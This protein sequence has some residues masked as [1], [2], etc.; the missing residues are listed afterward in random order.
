MMQQQPKALDA[1]LL[2]HFKALALEII[3]H[4]QPM[5][6]EPR[7]TTTRRKRKQAKE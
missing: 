3:K 6:E 1:E 7:K 5:S 4:E 2:N